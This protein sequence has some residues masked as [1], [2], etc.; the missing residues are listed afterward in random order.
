MTMTIFNQ[1]N[2]SMV[3]EDTMTIAEYD[4]MCNDTINDSFTAISDL[5]IECATD[6]SL[7]LGGK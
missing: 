4:A 3:V 6:N 5:D 2:D 7:C 1:F